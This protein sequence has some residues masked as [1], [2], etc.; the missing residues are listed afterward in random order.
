MPILK[1]NTRAFYYPALALLL[2]FSV[3]MVSASADAGA[4]AR[5]N[6]LEKQ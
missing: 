4:P 5:L 6:Q 3:S 1:T 2:S